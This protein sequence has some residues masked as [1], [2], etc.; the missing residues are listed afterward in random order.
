MLLA[1]STAS[2]METSTSH[3]PQTTSSHLSNPFLHKIY[4]YLNP[5][6]GLNF[7]PTSSKNLP[8]AHSLYFVHLHTYLCSKTPIISDVI[9]Y[10][11]EEVV[12]NIKLSRASLS[13]PYEI[14]RYFYPRKRFPQGH[15]LRPSETPLF[16]R[17]A[18]VQET[19]EASCACHPHLLVRVGLEQIRNDRMWDP[20]CQRNCVGGQKWQHV[21]YDSYSFFFESAH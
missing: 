20:I 18:I 9:N 14:C 7:N 1:I 6:S 15:G 5:S 2:T 13:I 21:N 10:K 19:A 12:Y 8:N 17:C 4:T 16:P 3:D 11:V